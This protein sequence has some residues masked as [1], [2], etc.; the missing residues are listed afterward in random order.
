MTWGVA[1]L[2]ALLW[3]ACATSKAPVELVRAESL[4]SQGRT[5]EALQAYEA[6]TYSCQNQSNPESRQKWCAAAQLGR[7]SSLERLGRTAEAI[8]AYETLAGSAP[9]SFVPT[10]GSTAHPGAIALVSAG[11]L[12]LSSAGHDKQAYERFW[13]TIT[14]YPNDPYADEALRI[15]MRDGRKRDAQALFTQLDQLYQWF[16]GTEIADNLLNAMASL[17]REEMAN[18]AEAMRAYDLL[19]K[20]HASSPFRDDALYHGAQLSEAIKDYKG[21]AER[22]RN[23]LDTREKSFLVGS[24]HSSWLDDAQL[25]LGRLVRDRLGDPR[26]ALK[27]FA[28]LEDRFP[29]SALVDEAL[30]EIARTHELLGD[31][32]HACKALGVLKSR[33]P[34]S[35]FHQEQIP[36]ATT[37][38]HCM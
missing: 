22:Y 26:S 19:V 15:L 18:P 20:H 30:F 6:A 1:C 35:K 24:Y 16:S 3:L 11:R 27:E 32:E 7:A 28:N 38:L 33:F 21:A 36:Q 8:V 12:H 2:A 10:D 37:R 34:E 9:S 31:W 14:S 5:L 4:D 29:D 17:A 23:L 13:K 25:A